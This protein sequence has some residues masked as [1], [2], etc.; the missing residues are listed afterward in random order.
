MGSVV[1]EG[2]AFFCPVRTQAINHPDRIAVYLQHEKALSY[3]AFDHCV[4]VVQ[5]Q[6]APQISPGD[7]VVVQLTNSFHQVVLLL[8][9][10]RCRAVVVP[11]NPA[12]STNATV[13]CVGK[14]TARFAFPEK[15][16]NVL[17]IPLLQLSFPSLDIGEDGDQRQC[18]S[19]ALGTEKQLATLLFTSGSIGEPKVVAHSLG[20]YWAS[21]QGTLVKLPLAPDDCWLLSL[22]L[23]HVGG[24]ATLWRVWMAGAA[25][26]IAEDKP[27]QLAVYLQLPITHCSLVATQ[28][29]R[30]LIQGLANNSGQLKTIILGGGPVPDSLLATLPSSIQSWM[31]YGLTEMTAMVTL[32]RWQ[33]DSQLAGCCLPRREIMLHTNG[34]IWVRGE[35]LCL[36]Y[37]QQGKIRSIIN[38]RGWF[39]TRDIGQWCQQDKLLPQKYLKVLGRLDAQFISGGENIQPEAIEAI[40]YQQEGVQRALVCAIADQEFGQ[41][42]V[43][44]IEVSHTCHW[45]PGL[46]QLPITDQL[47]RY[48]V[49]DHWLRWPEAL[50]VEGLKVSRQQLKKWAELQLE[51]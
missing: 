27:Y 48:C 41:R 40:L 12:L 9:L 10:W 20:N 13:S 3:S 16:A 37:W 2:E 29:Q 32:G 5:Q 14:V 35:T 33:G 15:T 1:T 17:Q 46:W 47:P 34:E 21:A 11:L 22:P 28:L 50:Q 25:L 8:A 18:T 45:Q 23:Y 19:L 7:Q 24:L 6:L 4:S 39:A 31:S 42:P 43:A 38:E 30:L 51:A 44:I 36:G 26:A 49:P